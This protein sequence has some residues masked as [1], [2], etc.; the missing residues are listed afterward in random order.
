MLAPDGLIAW[1]VSSDTGISS[2]AIVAQ[3]TG[4]K[5]GDDGWGD[6]PHDSDDF[7]R[8]YRLLEA[9]PEFRERI[10]EMAAR[11]PEWKALVKRWDRLSDLYANGNGCSAAIREI[12]DS[13]SE[14]RK[15]GLGGGRC[16][17]IVVRLA[18]SGSIESETGRQ[19]A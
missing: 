5:S 14:R 15:A 8:C 9:V 7:G 16:G 17:G 19:G 13:V 2:K 3:M 10:G 6:H 4:T 18:G 12:L 11:S 1:L